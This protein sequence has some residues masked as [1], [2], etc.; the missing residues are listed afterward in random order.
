MSGPSLN[1][2]LQPQSSSRIDYEQKLALE[3]NCYSSFEAQAT[4]NIATPDDPKGR[5][6]KGILLF[7]RQH[8]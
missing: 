1:S 5:Y 7:R 3:S 4:L 2:M 8:T 6:D